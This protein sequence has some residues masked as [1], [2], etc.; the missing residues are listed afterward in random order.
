[1]QWWE[2]E[3][4]QRITAIR[5]AA[6]K[7]IRRTKLVRDLTVK[8]FAASAGLNEAEVRRVISKGDWEALKEKSLGERTFRAI[9]VI[10]GKAYFQ[11]DITL[12]KIMKYSGLERVGRAH[13]NH[14]ELSVD[15]L[16]PSQPSSALI[17]SLLLDSYLA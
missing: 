4:R 14:L 8:K 9:R 6:K 12:Q 10:S 1:M 5:Q 16:H 7:Y 2:R 15:T 17:L 13:F 3:K 11:E